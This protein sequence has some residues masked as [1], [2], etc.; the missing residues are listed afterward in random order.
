MGSWYAQELL[1]RDRQRELDAEVD[2]ARVAALV[3]PSRGG[4]PRRRRRRI[5][6]LLAVPVPFTGAALTIHVDLRRAGR[7]P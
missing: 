5:A 4:G 6:R 7:A 1:I 3:R 2:R